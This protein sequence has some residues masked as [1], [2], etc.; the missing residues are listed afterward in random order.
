MGNRDNRRFLC[1]VS[2]PHGREKVLMCGFASAYDLDDFII[3]YGSWWING[4]I[5]HPSYPLDTISGRHVIHTSR[6][7][8][9]GVSVGMHLLYGMRKIHWL[10]PLRL[11]SFGIEHA[12]VTGYGYSFFVILDCKLPFLQGKIGRKNKKPQLHRYGFFSKKCNLK[13][14]FLRICSMMNGMASWI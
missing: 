12:H 11:R 10:S 6:C 3:R 5:H 8:T 1:L 9:N 4:M 2:G 7:I 14:Y 13:Y